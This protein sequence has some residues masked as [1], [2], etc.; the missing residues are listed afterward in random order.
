MQYNYNYFYCILLF[1]T[2]RSYAEDVEVKC[3][4]SNLVFLVY[5]VELLNISL[6]TVRVWIVC[7]LAFTAIF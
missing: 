6:V 2:V 3:E 5:G 1:Q 7:P 4:R